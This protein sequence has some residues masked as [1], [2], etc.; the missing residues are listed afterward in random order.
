MYHVNTK[1]RKLDKVGDV[2][3]LHHDSI[4]TER[5]YC[6]WIKR[7]VLFHQMKPHEELLDGEQKTESF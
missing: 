4:L 5:I 6:D 2:M 7:Y 3:R 1:T